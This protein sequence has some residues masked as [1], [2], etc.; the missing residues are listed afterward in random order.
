MRHDPSWTK[1]TRLWFG[2]DTLALMG[3]DTQAAQLRWQLRWSLGGRER[4]QGRTEED[5][6]GGLHMAT[7]AS[8]CE[9]TTG[10]W[11]N[12]I[13]KTRGFFGWRRC[14][15]DS[16]HSTAVATVTKETHGCAAASTKHG[17]SERKEVSMGLAA[18]RGTHWVAR[19]DQR[20]TGAAVLRWPKVKKNEDGAPLRQRDQKKGGNQNRTARSTR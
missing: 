3:I 19:D 18:T 17:R 13:P 14:G 1:S 5:A 8:G 9:Q 11:Q 2:F 16:S 15:N 7:T 10:K 6:S 4:N 20:M 12:R